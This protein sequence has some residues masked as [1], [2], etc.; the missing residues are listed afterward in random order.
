MSGSAGTLPRSAPTRD[1]SGLK[2]D[3]RVSKPFRRDAANIAAEPLDN[4]CPGM[5]SCG[6]SAERTDGS[7]RSW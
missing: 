1:M 3:G 7:G 2:A 6:M 5:D 4:A